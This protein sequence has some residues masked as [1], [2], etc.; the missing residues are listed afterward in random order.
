[1]AERDKKNQLQNTISDHVNAIQTEKTYQ[2]SITI[3][4]V[5]VIPS[6]TFETENAEY[7]LLAIINNGTWVELKI[8]AIAGD[9][10]GR[11]YHVALEDFERMNK[12]ELENYFNRQ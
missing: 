4:G 6:D 3:S 5:K 1:M 8:M 10:L 12:K 11:V 2:G 7:V 9:H